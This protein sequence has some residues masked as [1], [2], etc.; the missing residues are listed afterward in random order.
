M[1]WFHKFNKHVYMGPADDGEGSGGG[2]STPPANTATGSQEPKTFS[3]EYVRELR[4]ENKATRLKR[5][6]AEDLLKSAQEALT[7]AQ[8]EAD[9]KVIAARKSADERLLRAELK[10]AAV[11]AGLVDL[12]V[13]KLADIGEL[14]FND[15]GEI[16][17]L[18]KFIEDFKKAKPHFFNAAGA[19]TSATGTKPAPKAGNEPVDV[20]KMTPKE[21]AAHKQKML[22]GR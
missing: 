11:K 5:Q 9:D 8:K 2:G 21:Y 7:K 13:L 4:E 6:E 14:K 1:P 12:D 22:S 16:E 17:G 15:K 19:S 18:D 3:V 20:T 10:T